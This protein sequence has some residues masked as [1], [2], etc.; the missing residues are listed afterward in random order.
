[1]SAVGSVPVGAVAGDAGGLQV[2]V[3][4]H[5]VRAGG[6]SD[7]AVF[8]ADVGTL[9]LLIAKGASTNLFGDEVRVAALGQH[10]GGLSETRDQGVAVREARWL[11]GVTG[12]NC[13]SDL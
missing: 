1:M 13:D 8:Y 2:G 9:R 6:I 12:Y 10:G 3:W 5:S 11:V 4:S 7:G